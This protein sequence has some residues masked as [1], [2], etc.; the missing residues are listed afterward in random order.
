[1]SCICQSFL[2]S[3]ASTVIWVTPMHTFYL[4]RESEKIPHWFPVSNTQRTVYPKIH[5]QKFV[6][7]K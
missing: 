4:L 3:Q 7:A 1:M 2:K 6:W 5:R